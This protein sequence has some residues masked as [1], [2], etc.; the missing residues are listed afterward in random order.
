MVECRYDLYC[1]FTSSSFLGH[2]SQY[3]ISIKVQFQLVSLLSTVS[4]KS[5]EGCSYMLAV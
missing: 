2:V 5:I 1:L 3:G 4:S